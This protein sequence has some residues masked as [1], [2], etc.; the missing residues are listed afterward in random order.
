MRRPKN[1]PRDCDTTLEKYIKAISND[2]HDKATIYLSDDAETPLASISSI[3]GRLRVRFDKMDGENFLAVSSKEGT[4]TVP[5]RNVTDW[6]EHE[7][8]NGEIFFYVEIMGMECTLALE[9]M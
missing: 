7:G 4:I 2:G 5:E 6:T 1:H 9:F 8:R 3:D